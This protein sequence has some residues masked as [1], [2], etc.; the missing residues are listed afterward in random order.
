[1]DIYER[2]RKQE[3]DGIMAD[4][5]GFAIAVAVVTLFLGMLLFS[6]TAHANEWA[7][8]TIAYEASDQSF[9]GQVAVAE[10]IKTRIRDVRWPQTAKEV[11]HQPWQF[12]C[13]DPVTTEPTQTRELTEHELQKAQEAWDAAWYGD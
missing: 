3:R 13:W 11:V 6:C 5:A 7:I 9:E 12:S 8:K 10:V 2:I 4:L 1:M